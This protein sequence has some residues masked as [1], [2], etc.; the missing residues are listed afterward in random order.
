M[1]GHGLGEKWILAATEGREKA[2]VMEKGERDRERE[3]HTRR[4][5]PYGHWLGR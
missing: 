1:W 5:F 4:T 2:V 3:E